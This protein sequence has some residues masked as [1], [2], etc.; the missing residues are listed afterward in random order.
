M[1]LFAAPNQTLFQAETTTTVGLPEGQASYVG[2]SLGWRVGPYTLRG[3]MNFGSYPHKA[4]SFEGELNSVG[5]T[6]P[7][8]SRIDISS[9]RIDAFNWLIGHDL[10]LWSPKGFLT[11]SATTPGSILVGFHFERTD[12][13]CTTPTVSYTS[14]VVPTTGPQT[15]T[16]TLPG[17]SDVRIT[18]R[19]TRTI[20]AGGA[21]AIANEAASFDTND[22]GLA[23][24]A[25][26]RN[27]VLL[28]EWDIFYFFAPRASV[29][30]QV[31]W[32]D[33]ANLPA[34][35]ASAPG[36]QFNL[37]KAKRGFE[38]P[39]KGGEWVDTYLNFRWSF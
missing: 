1:L 18:A 27:R 35:T 20:T 32:Y 24:A 14:T 6:T 10:F 8:F 7:V 9:R 37:G 16:A 2:P 34:G 39:G 26:K 30:I 33:A 22:L 21:T 25:I 13:S 11:G 19:Q 5:T 4:Q 15:R 28:R 23:V 12:V 29:G 17:C 38:I 3:I 31:L 36:T